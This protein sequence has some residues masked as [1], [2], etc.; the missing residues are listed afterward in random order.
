MT[1]EFDEAIRTLAVLL[2][3]A[4]TPRGFVMSRQAN[5]DV[6]ASTISVDPDINGAVSYARIDSHT[7]KLTR[8]RA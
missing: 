3:K 1:E 8:L 4:D 2:A 7:G 5:G 6:L